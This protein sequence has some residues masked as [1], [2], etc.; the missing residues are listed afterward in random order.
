MADVPSPA[1]VPQVPLQSQPLTF[2]AGGGEMGDRMRR[3]DW[4]R[5][6]LGP[7]GDRPQSL[8]TAVR[9]ML[10]SRQPI[11]I[12]WGPELIFL[13]NDPYQAIIGGKHP[14]ALG[15]QT[16]VVWRE[17]WDVIGPMLSTAMAGDEGTS[18]KSQQP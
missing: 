13:Y 9:I 18:V 4:S 3:K 11:W 7:T 17:I 6:A 16:Q 15:E 5:T 10:T 14:Q 8:K 1:V 2:L 12:G